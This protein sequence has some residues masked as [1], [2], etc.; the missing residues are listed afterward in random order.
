MGRSYLG[1]ERCDVRM[2]QGLRGLYDK[3]IHCRHAAQ[4]T[5]GPKLWSHQDL[6]EARITVG[7]LYRV[8]LR[9]SELLA[10]RSPAE[11]LSIGL[12]GF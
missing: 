4:K 3:G 6:S 9:E 11:H 7:R 5:V 2:I 10:W 12:R 8:R 1:N